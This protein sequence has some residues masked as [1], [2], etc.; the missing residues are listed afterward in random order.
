VRLT[1]S[2]DHRAVDGVEVAMFLQFL[3]RM[4]ENPNGL[5]NSGGFK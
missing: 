2:A 3:R 5:F 4:L 1:V